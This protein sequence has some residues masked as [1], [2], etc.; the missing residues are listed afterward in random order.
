MLLN[1]SLISSSSYDVLAI[2]QHLHFIHIMAYNYHIPNLF[3]KKFI[4]FSKTSITVHVVTI[5]GWGHLIL[6]FSY[7]NNGTQCPAQNASQHNGPIAQCSKVFIRIFFFLFKFSHRRP[8]INVNLWA[9]FVWNTLH[10]FSTHS[11]KCRRTQWNIY[12][13]LVHH[14]INSGTRS[15]ICRKNFYSCG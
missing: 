12:W 4:F 13:H 2:N 3:S 10:L 11:F 1:V 5:L 8:I 15:S 7:R 14:R 6:S 9:L